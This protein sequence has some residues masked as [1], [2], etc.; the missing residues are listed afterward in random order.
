VTA[1]TVTG[2][3]GTIKY[4]W[5]NASSE[6]GTTASVANLPAGTYT[7]TVSDD[8]SSKSNSVTVGQPA[9]LALAASTK[10]DA[11][12]FGTSTGSVTA[13]TVTGAVGTIK[14]SWKNAS[15]VEVGTTASVANLPAGTY[16]LTVS[17]DCSSKSNSVTVGQ[18]ATA[19]ALAASTKSDATCF[20][21]SRFCDCWY[22]NRSFRYN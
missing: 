16:T 4:S 11:T 8:C 14:Y 1:G 21:T 7:L 13:G 9:A 19:L 6:V 12:C 5:K 2:A 20:G 15:S 18:P 22:G 3:V 10:S 17:D